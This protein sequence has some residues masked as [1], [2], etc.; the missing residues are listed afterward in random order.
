MTGLVCTRRFRPSGLLTTA[1]HFALLQVE[2]SLHAGVLSDLAQSP[3]VCFGTPWE[4]ADFKCSGEVNSPC[5]KGLPVGQNLVRAI[6][7]APPVAGTQE[8]LGEKKAG[9]PK[10][11]CL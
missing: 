7:R 3:M 9:P 8:E 1:Q 4:P 2:E 10:R 5:A 11:S 6:R